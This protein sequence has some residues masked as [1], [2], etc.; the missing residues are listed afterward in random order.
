MRESEQLR[1]DIERYGG[2]ERTRLRRAVEDAF[3]FP[4]PE[5]FDVDE[6]LRLNPSPDIT[7][8]LDVLRDVDG[9]AA[10]WLHPYPWA[11]R[12]PKQERKNR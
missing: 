6:Y 2:N 1:D 11:A 12:R 10:S 9:T 5:G 7:A 4:K 3:S 8:V